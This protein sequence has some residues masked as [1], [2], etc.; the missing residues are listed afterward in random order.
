MNAILVRLA[1]LVA[2]TTGVCAPLRAAATFE[3]R[4]KMQM[5]TGKK[6]KNI[7]S[8]AIKGQHL[9]VEIPSG[10]QT[11]VGLLDWEK[12]EMSMLMPGQQMYMVID[13]KDSVVA[14]KIEKA[15]ESTT[16]EKTSETA[17]IVGHDT[18]KYIARD[19]KTMTELWLASGIGS[20]FNMSGGNPMKPKKMPEWE[21]EVIAKGLF[22]LRMVSYDKAGKPGVKMEVVELTPQKLEDSLFVP[23]PGYTRFSM[24][25][26]LK[27]LSGL[28]K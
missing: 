9:R 1:F 26:M 13:L 12:R 6:E 16:L 21:K 10:A 20:W 18:T 15:Q 14:D 24:G 27:G 17:T 2:V 8:Y 28:G 22:P 5:D 4:I 7:L 19:G 25:G 11:M 3:G 23:P